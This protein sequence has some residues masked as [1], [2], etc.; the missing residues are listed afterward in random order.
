MPKSKLVRRIA[1]LLAA[2]LVAF[3]G[4]SVYFAWDFTGRQRKT[5]RPLPADF[6][7]AVEN[8]GFATLDG[9]TLKGWY[10]PCP[11]STRGVV[12]LH[13]HSTTRSQMT[14]RAKLLRNS[15]YAVLLY[16]AR[17]HGESGGR[18]ASVGWYETRDLEAALEFL[19]VKGCKR[20]GCVGVSQGGATIA[21]AAPTLKNV[22]WVVLES[23]YPDIRTALDRRFR[24]TVFLPGSIAGMFMT[25]LAGRR[26][27]VNVDD[28]APVKTIG[29]LRCP[30]LIMS[31]DADRYTTRE[32]TQALFAA[33]REPKE[34]WLVPNALHVD[35]Y[36]FA[37]KAYED[38][39]LAFIRKN[40]P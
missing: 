30:I 9:I 39:L 7:F 27:G 29:Q 11:G 14:A 37:Q 35:L 15:G 33:A 28:I 3:V 6:G 32:D 4:V 10:V 2:G 16:D 1:L 38:H 26:L 20:L 22:D 34:L 21:L 40:S 18:F 36:G 8:V 12:L 23:A 24:D 5:V 17:A 13:G 25:P 19:R 31:G